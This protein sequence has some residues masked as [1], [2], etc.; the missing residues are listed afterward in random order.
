MRGQAYK[1]TPF[2]RYDN[3]H[4]G[5]GERCYTVGYKNEQRIIE[6]FRARGWNVTDHN[7]DGDF[8]RGYDITIAK[9]GIEARVEIK[10]QAG[11]AAGRVYPTFFCETHHGGG[12]ASGWTLPSSGCTHFVITNEHERKVYIF[13]S[14][15]LRAK[16][17]DSSVRE[18]HHNGCKGKLIG[19]QDKSAGFKCAVSL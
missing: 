3:L 17:M 16:L 8:F 19:W 10:H 13:N 12:G 18:T 9:D 15:A 5:E 4:A 11:A 6:M 14:E 7:S 1:D 2:A